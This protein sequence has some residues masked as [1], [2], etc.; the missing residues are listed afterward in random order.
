MI[1]K[2]IGTLVI[3]TAG[4]LAF[5]IVQDGPTGNFIRKSTSSENCVQLTPAQQLVKLI[6]DDIDNLKREGQLPQQWNSIATIEYKVRSELARTL[7]GSEKLTLQRVKEGAFFLEVEVLDM[8]DEIDPGIILQMSLKDIKTKNKIFEIGRTYLM[9]TLNRQQPPAKQ[10][11]PQQQSNPPAQ[12]SAAQ[13][14]V[15]SSK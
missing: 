15:K 1:Y 8:P 3:L 10:K 7:L 4:V 11:A 14:P 5:L 6:N 9:S 13:P 2:L 12:P